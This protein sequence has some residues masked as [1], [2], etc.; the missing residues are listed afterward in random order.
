MPNYF[1]ILL[2]S[3]L[4]NQVLQNSTAF[5]ELSVWFNST[6]I[7]PVFVAIVLPM[8]L[9]MLIGATPGFVG[10]SFPIILAIAGNSSYG[11]FALAFTSGVIGVLFSPMHL[12]IVLTCDYFRTT[13]FKV[14]KLMLFPAIAQM[15]LGILTWWVSLHL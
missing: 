5:G 4:L 15:A 2:G 10:V 7:P 1:I 11:I 9:G 8:I 3:I 14:F 12:C 6:G 13:L